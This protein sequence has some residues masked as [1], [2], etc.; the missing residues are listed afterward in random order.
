MAAAEESVK[1]RREF[2]PITMVCLAVFLLASV[3]VIGVAVSDMIKGEDPQTVQYGDSVTIDYTGSLYGY[4]DEGTDT[5]KPIIFDTTLESVGKNADY[6]F[7]SS[8]NKTSFSSTTLTLGAGKFLAEFEQAIM[9]KQVGETFKIP[10]FV[11]YHS[12]VQTKTATAPFVQNNSIV[13]TK[14]EIKTYFGYEGDITGLTPLTYD[15]IKLNDEPVQATAVPSGDKYVVSFDMTAGE[16]YVIYDNGLGKVILTPSAVG[17]AIT[18]TLTVDTKIDVENP[19]TAYSDIEMLCV[20]TFPK[21]DSINI[22]GL[23]GANIVYNTATDSSAII[24]EMELY[25]V[26]TIVKKN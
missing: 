2:E 16:N 1:V 7:V 23:D 24:S 17:A 20:K 21:A 9:G 4:Y 8:F 5:V 6:F 26:V 3:I 25:F 10:A 11:G 12:A 19:E 18:Y 14:D 13:L 22:V 15:G